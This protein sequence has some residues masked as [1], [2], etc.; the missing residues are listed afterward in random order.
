MSDQLGAADKARPKP[1][2][3]LAC[4]PCRRSHLKCDGVK[5]LCSRCAD[6]RID[7]VWIESR[8]GYRDYR[9]GGNAAATGNTQKPKRRDSGYF[10]GPRPQHEP[11]P[12]AYVLD[13]SLTAAHAF[14]YDEIFNVPFPGAE[15]PALYGDAHAAYHTSLPPVA[16]LTPTSSATKDLPTPVSAREMQLARSDTHG[17]HEKE[18]S[19][20]ID[21][22]YKYFF[23]S[24]PF[25]VPQKLY[26]QRPDTIPEGLKA[27]MRFIAAHYVPNHNLLALQ[28]A[29]AVIF[30]DQ[31]PDDVYKIQALMLYMCAA[32]A[33]Y[34]Q[35]QGGVAL[36]NAIRIAMQIGLNKHA[37]AAT[38]E[39]HNAVMQ[40]SIR[41][42]WWTLFIMEGLITAIGGQMSPFRLHRL[43]CDVP[44]PGDDAAYMA[45]KSSMAPRSL[46]D[47][48]N[49]TFA[50]DNYA[51]SSFAYAIEAMYIM[52]AVFELGPDTFAITDHQVEAIDASISNFTLSLPQD[53]RD[54]IP[55][56][57]GFVDETLL[58]AHMLINWAAILVH[59]PRSTLTFIRNHYA[60]ICTRVEAAGLPA[61]AY[62]SHTSKTL[63]AANTIINLATVQ[64]PITY[65]TPSMVCGITTAATVHLPAYAI[66]DTPGH[67][68]AIKERLQL[69]ISALGR[70]AEI[71]PRA[72]IAK[73]QVASFA[74]EVLTRPSVCV[75]ST[76]PSLPCA[77]PLGVVAG[78][79][80]HGVGGGGADAAA[81]GASGGASAGGGGMLL[82]APVNT[83]LGLPALEYVGETVAADGMVDPP[84]MESSASEEEEGEGAAADEEEEEG[85]VLDELEGMPAQSLP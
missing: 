32:F 56:P 84:V 51:Y 59:R 55:D 68:T 28:K 83:G 40:E 10:Y 67:A 23:G 72:S 46:A 3:L 18:P 36:E 45:L 12:E 42:T 1:P 76:A 35:M 21:L 37:F 22:F 39:P 17:S 16:E 73:S 43:Y 78:R 7:C 8:R 11:V 61:L 85:W 47:F 65:C 75:D 60:T 41:R 19:D 57:D 64:R 52:G 25:V 63:R 26:R 62:A 53:K 30:T 9:K 34:E 80:S 27:C 44:L 70:F 4:I 58:M 74:R 24:H 15:M 77:T 49:R 14:T 29:T 20:L 13:A 71:W 81:A 6:K 38:V 82:G 2:S 54:V 5:P 33:R 69:G 48:R 50:E 79:E 31:M 66:A